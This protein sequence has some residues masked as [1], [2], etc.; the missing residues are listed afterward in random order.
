MT[1]L[2]WVTAFEADLTSHHISS[3][4]VSYGNAVT[5]ASNVSLMPW[6]AHVALESYPDG[7]SLDRR[8]ELIYR[9]GAGER[10]A[11]KE[12]AREVPGDVQV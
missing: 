1:E 10:I 9:D 2:Y 4:I 7:K 11:R 12:K 6:I 5:V 8:L 3:G